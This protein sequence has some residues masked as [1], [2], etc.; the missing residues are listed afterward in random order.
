[1]HCL[2]FFFN[3]LLHSSHSGV[4]LHFLCDDCV[5]QAMTLDMTIDQFA[6]QREA[7]RIQL[8]AQYGVDPSLITLEAAAAPRQARVLRHARVLQSGSGLKLTITIATS[9][10]EAPGRSDSHSAP[11]MNSLPSTA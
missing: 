9:D 3:N 6:A 4:W 2:A 1:M 11:S 5:V 8:A 7:L 10:G